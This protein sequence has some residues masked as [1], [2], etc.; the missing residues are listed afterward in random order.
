MSRVC[1]GCSGNIATDSVNCQVCLATYHPSCAKSTNVLPNSGFQRCC[2]T[3]KSFSYEDLRKLIREENT[4]IETR[5]SA[6]INKVQGSIDTLSKSVSERLSEIE[7][8]NRALG[9][10][11]NVLEG[12]VN[13][14]TD[15]INA[16][17][18]LSQGDEESILE[19]VEE[20]F[21]RR[22]NVVLFN[23]PESAHTDIES[24]SSAD[25]V[26]VNKF[27]SALDIDVPSSQFRIGKYSP[28]L[29]EPRPLK[30]TFSN[31]SHPD[32]II[33]NFIRAKKARQ[34]PPDLNLDNVIITHDRTR[35]QQQQHRNIREEL[36]RRIADGENNL[37]LVTRRGKTIIFSKPPPRQGQE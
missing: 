35:R 6:E 5:I 3:K 24:R 10:R 18:N 11:V 20:R 4:A 31:S 19:E 16:F 30:I 32:L 28:A 2:G 36:Q 27:C 29:K 12:K 17:G 25:L 34:L 1:R 26:L 15:K 23:F 21:N 8:G 14:N 13:I 7:A 33:Q 37:R 9:D 22:N